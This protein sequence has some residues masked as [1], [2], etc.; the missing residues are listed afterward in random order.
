M[1]SKPAQNQASLSSA[2]SLGRHHYYQALSWVPGFAMASALAWSQWSQALGHPSN[3]LMAE[4]P[5]INLT[6]IAHPSDQSLRDKG[7]KHAKYT[8][9]FY[10]PASSC[11]SSLSPGAFWGISVPEQSP[12]IPAAAGLASPAEPVPKPNPKPQ[13]LCHPLWI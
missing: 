7:A 3:R 2:I 5:V 11:S 6:P 8:A 9:S 10:Y 12:P 1:N 13:D 4:D